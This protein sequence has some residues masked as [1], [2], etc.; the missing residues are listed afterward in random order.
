MAWHMGYPLS[1]TLFT[2]LY[3]DRLL[4]PSP[5]SLE[6]TY[7]DKS[8]NRPL[9]EPLS[10]QILRAYCLGLVKTCWFVNNR[11]RSEHFYEVCPNVRQ[12]I[13]AIL[14]GWCRKKTLSPILTIEVCLITWITS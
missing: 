14:I 7:F 2:S 13:W 6:Q 5:M 11:V 9:Q 4:M 12:Q 3:I 8:D 10:I 1:Q